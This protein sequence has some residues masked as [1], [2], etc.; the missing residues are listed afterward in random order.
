[1]LDQVK[2]DDPTEPF[3][4]GVE[5][6]DAGSGA[7]KVTFRDPVEPL[8]LDIGDVRVACHLHDPRFAEQVPTAG[9]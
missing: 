9:P 5:A 2:S 8:L 1:L 3:W 7:A 4:R 6:I